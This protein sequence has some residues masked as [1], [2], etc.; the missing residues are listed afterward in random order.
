MPSP[1][2][3]DFENNEIIIDNNH[4]I[5]I[6]N[7]FSNVNIPGEPPIIKNS[8]QAIMYMNYINEK[9]ITSGYSNEYNDLLRTYID[10]KTRTILI[11]HLSSCQCCIRH[12]CRRPSSSINHNLEHCHNNNIYNLLPKCDCICRHTIRW[13]INNF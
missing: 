12:C 1:P 2:G 11:N 8:K 9:W 13:L 10:K 3:G 4:N 6:E 7:N 5:D